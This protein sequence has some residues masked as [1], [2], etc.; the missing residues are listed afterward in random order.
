MN[1]IHVTSLGC[2][3]N[4]VDS[5]VMVGLLEKHGWTIVVKPQ[6]ADVLLVNTCGFIQPAVEEG[7]DEILNLASF[8]EKAPD[9]KLVVTGCMVQRYR[10]TLKEEIPEIDVLIGTEGIIDIVN[11]LQQMVDGTSDNVLHMPEPFLMDATLP[12]RIATPPFRAWLKVTEGCNNHCSYCMIPS[13]RGALRSREINDLVTEAETLGM[14]GVKELTLIAQDLTAYGMDKNSKSLLVPLLR[15]LT[16]KTEIPWIR[17]LYLYPSGIEED[18]LSLM[19]ENSRIVPYLDIPMQHISDT[20]LERM[21]RRYS[22][23]DLQK[24]IDKIRSYLP[25][26]ALRT[27]FLLGFPGETEAD[28]V[29]LESFL[30]HAKIDHVGVFPYANE[31]GCPSEF[32]PNQ[33]SEEEKKRRVSR[34]LEVQSSVSEEIQRKY[35][36]RIEPVLIEGLSSETDLLLEGRTRF[37]APE[38]DGCVYINDGVAKPGDIVPVRI[39]ESQTYDLIGA[40]VH[41]D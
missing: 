22:S 15:E 2:P 13:I 20:V 38:I 36:T 12:R 28:I 39:D 29:Q 40:I 37:Q 16:K 17:L 27:T 11:V 23:D 6:D 7:I 18:L 8:K 19:H 5:E 35:L 14:S 32:Y 3:K 31:E 9:K 24:L 34:I 10:E 25:D 1:T 33:I 4:F 21:N 30:H 26:V 41:P